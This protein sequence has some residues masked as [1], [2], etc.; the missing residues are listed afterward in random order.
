MKSAIPDDSMMFVRRTT[1]PM[2]VR[3]K[4]EVIATPNSVADRGVEAAAG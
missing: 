4:R 3:K 1:N 2:M